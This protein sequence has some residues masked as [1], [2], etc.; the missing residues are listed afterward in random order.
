MALPINRRKFIRLAAAGAAG[1]LAAD[2]ILL[3]PNRPRIVNQ[4]IVLRRWPERLN[5]LTIALLSDFHYDPLFSAHPIHAAISMVNAAKPD[6]IVLTGDFV[7]VPILEAGAKGALAAE[8]CAEL[9]RQMRAPMGSWAC[10]GNHDAFSD[11]VRVMGALRNSGIQVLANQAVPLEKDGARFWLTGVN[12]VM[13]GIADVQ[14]TLRN[15]PPTE[16]TVMLVHEPDFAD[17]VKRFPVDLQLSG[18]SHGGQVRIPGLLPLYLPE[19][20]RK[21]DMGL[22]KIGELTLYTNPGLGTVR[23]PVRLNCPPEITVLR[24]RQG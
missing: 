20:A 13:A 2:G 6:L 19:L 17:H 7:S 9:L 14:G 4:Q 16:A 8:P 18:H 10:L 24:L 12:D 21:Y 15:V 1:V 11:P 5:G 23:L 3:Q 22:Y